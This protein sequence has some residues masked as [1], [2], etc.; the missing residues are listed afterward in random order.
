MDISCTGPTVS[1]VIPCRNE[2]D[3]IETCLRSILAQEPPPGGFEVIVAD[4]MS[5]DGTRDILLRLAREDPRLH[6]VENPGCIV[7]TGLNTAIGAAQGRII[8]RMDAH[9]QLR[10]RLFPPM[11]TWCSRRRVQTMSAAHGSPK[12]REP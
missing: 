2:K 11:Y 6:I 8:V 4:G 7:S 10:A 12:G 9:T 1:V 3:Y 5:D